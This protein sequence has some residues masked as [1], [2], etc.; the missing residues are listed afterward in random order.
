MGTHAVFGEAQKWIEQWLE[1][2]FADECCGVSGRSQVSC[3]AWRIFWQ[4]YTVHPHAVGCN[5]LASEHGAA[6]WH[7]HN[8]LWM[9][10][11]KRDAMLAQGINRWRA[12]NHSAV[13]TECVV[14]L[15]VGGDEKNLAAQFISDQ[16]FL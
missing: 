7:A 3:N 5:V 8:I 9:R 12:R 2:R 6:R 10:T 1:V 14:A 13:A 15:L 16:T 4:G 11:I